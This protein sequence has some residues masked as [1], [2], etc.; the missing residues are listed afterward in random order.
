MITRVARLHHDGYGTVF[1]ALQEA[2]CHAGHAVAACKKPTTWQ[3]TQVHRRSS[4]CTW[5]FHSGTTADTTAAC[6]VL[7]STAGSFCWEEAR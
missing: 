3:Q 7:I 5:C 2:H 4:T 6:T 1:E